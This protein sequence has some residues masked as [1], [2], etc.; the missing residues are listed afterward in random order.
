M[1]VG[2][3]DYVSNTLDLMAYSKHVMPN[4]TV[5]TDETIGSVTSQKFLEYV[6][7]VDKHTQPSTGDLTL[8]EALTDHHGNINITQVV[9][10]FSDG[11]S[12][13]FMRGTFTELCGHFYLKFGNYDEEDVLFEQRAAAALDAEV[14]TWDMWVGFDD[15]ASSTLDL[16]AN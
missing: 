4:A 8:S 16:V 9:L 6:A 5:Y 2:I 12:E 11:N 1:R 7:Y 14:Y 10:L 13:L 3:G 15:Y